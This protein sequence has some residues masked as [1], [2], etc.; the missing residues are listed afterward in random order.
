MRK[1]LLSILLVLSLMLTLV[2]AAFAADIASGT[3][4]AEGDGSNVIWTLDETGLLTISGTGKIASGTGGSIWSD[5]PVLAVDIRSGVTGVGK[6]AFYGCDDLQVISLP[7][8]VTQLDDNAFG[9]CP[10]LSDILVDAKNPAYKSVDGALYSKD[11]TVLVKGP[12]NAETFV[13]P[14]GVATIGDYAFFGAKYLTSI[15]FPEGSLTTIGAMAFEFCEGLTELLLPAGVT[16]IGYN[17]FSGCTQLKDVILPDGLTRIDMNVFNRCSALTEVTIPASVTEVRGFSFM[18]CTALTDVY[19]TGTQAQWDAVRIDTSY[20]D[21]FKNAAVHVDAEQHVFGAWQTVEQPGCEQPGT[22]SRTCTNGCGLKQTAAVPALGHDWDEGVVTT[23]PDGVLCGILHVT[24]KRCGAESDELLMPEIWAYEQ[25]GDVDPTLW[26]YE[27]I[28]FCVMMGFM[29]GMDTHVFAPRGVT[30]RA[31]LV[32]ILYNFVGGPEVSGETPF[33]DL[34]AN[35][36]KDAVLWAYQTGVTS[37]TSET[38]FAPDD[39]VTRE[40]VAVLLYEFADKVLEVG[41][42]ETPADLSRFPDGDQVSSWAREAMADAVAL[43]IINGTKVDDQV[44][45]APQGSATRD[46]IAT[47]FEGF[48]AS[49]A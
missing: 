10:A 32:Q 2:P 28:Q 14:D 41:G 38:T 26:S 8:T 33:T 27:G 17:A 22:I 34:T 1:K 11:G 37:G 5:K 43:G 6:D 3:C 19:Y 24:C 4:G 21:P 47:M 44:F 31:Q 45:L 42:A 20:G 36:Y 35:W 29:S 23:E 49:L 46:Q 16:A 30:T 48:C 18:G 25:F 13:V 12:A 39:P 15:Y 7:D 40:Q 9:N